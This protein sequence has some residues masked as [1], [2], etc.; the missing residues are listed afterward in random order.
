MIKL[1]GHSISGCY[2]SCLPNPDPPS[3]LTL[4]GFIGI[5]F[6]TFWIIWCL[7]FHFNPLINHQQKS[8][9]HHQPFQ[10]FINQQSLPTYLLDAFYNHWY[11]CLLPCLQHLDSHQSP[12]T[13][14]YV[15]QCLNLFQS[16][17]D[18]HHI[19]E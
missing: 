10:S 1:V 17:P 12:P 2:V 5:T 18:F 9:Y 4:V 6:C 14:S 3:F 19:F 7:F 11:S 16:S 13:I 8:S 15:I